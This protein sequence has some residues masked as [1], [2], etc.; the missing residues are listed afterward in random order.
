[1]PA[2]ATAT[3]PTVV[4]SQAAC[5]SRWHLHCSGPGPAEKPL[6]QIWNSAGLWQADSGGGGASSRKQSRN[7][8]HASAYKDPHVRTRMLEQI[9]IATHGGSWVF[10]REESLCRPHES[11][12]ELQAAPRVQQP[13]AAPWIRERRRHVPRRRCRAPTV[14]HQTWMMMTTSAHHARPLYSARRSGRPASCIYAGT[15]RGTHGETRESASIF[16][17]RITRITYRVVCKLDWSP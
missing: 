11:Q 13:E 17:R 12:H 8:L 1:M 10:H 3:A 2:L 7:D 6:D 9:C 16:S 5:E 4:R 14:R 15:S